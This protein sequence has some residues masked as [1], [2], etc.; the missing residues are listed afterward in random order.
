MMLNNTTGRLCFYVLLV[1][2]AS[3]AFTQVLVVSA[4]EVSN[5]DLEKGDSDLSELTVD[6]Y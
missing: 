5:C 2:I 4:L 6:C 1:S 3:I